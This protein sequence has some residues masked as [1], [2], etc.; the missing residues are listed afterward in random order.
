MIRVKND[1]TK[2]VIEKEIDTIEQI[3]LLDFSK[4]TGIKLHLCSAWI[5]YMDFKE[6]HHKLFFSNFIK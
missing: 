6:D 3:V 4:K 2:R 1:D 5:R